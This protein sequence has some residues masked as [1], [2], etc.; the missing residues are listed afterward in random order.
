V[1]VVDELSKNLV[2]GR[3]IITT[4]APSWRGIR[5]DYVTASR[6]FQEWVRQRR[7]DMDAAVLI[8]EVEENSPAWAEGLRPNMMISHV[9]SKSVSTPKDFYQAIGGQDGP[10]RVRLAL[11]ADDNP[12]RTIPPAG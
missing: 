10:V 8:T 2:W 11:P 6:E 1:V 5:V 3:K 7:V 9:G 4:P 12:V